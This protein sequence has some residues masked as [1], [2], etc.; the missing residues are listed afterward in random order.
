MASM[1]F[2]EKPIALNRDRHRLLK[3]RPQVGQFGFASTTNSVLMAAAEIVDAARDYPVVFVAAADGQYVLASL[4]GLHD[5]ENLFVDR[6]GQWRAGAY[7]PAFVRRYPFV[8]AEN[9]G[10][11]LTVC[12]DEGFPGLNEAEGEPLFDEEGKDTGLLEGAVE[13]LKRFH[14]E[15]KRTR[16]FTGKL[17]ALG[18]LEPRTIRVTREGKQEALEGLY[19]VDEQKLRALDDAQVL[20]LFRSGYLPWIEAHLASLGNVE[21]LARMQPAAAADEPGNPGESPAGKA[22]A[23]APG[24]RRGARSRKEPE[25]A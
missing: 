1:I 23:D 20:E 11:Q 19:V 5:R 12:V 3:L 18:L 21:R 10:S 13:F 2:Y 14:A 22:P 17:A 7:L 16:D 4:L 25:P 8:L 9:D 6:A 15:M 24:P